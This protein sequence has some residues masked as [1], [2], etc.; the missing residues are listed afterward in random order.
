MEYFFYFAQCS[1][2][3]L[4]AGY[5]ANIQEREKIHN[6]GKGA[7]FTAGRRPIKIIYWEEFETQKEAMQ[8]EIQVKKWCREKKEK[9]IKE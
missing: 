5:T 2:G 9:L 7:K 6:Q 1:D 4:Y 3:S 8:R